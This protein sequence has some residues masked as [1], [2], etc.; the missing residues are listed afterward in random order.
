MSNR[1]YGDFHRVRL[2][3]RC[4]VPI[5]AEL[6]AGE[7]AAADRLAEAHRLLAG[8]VD[9]VR[10]LERMG[11]AGSEVEAVRDELVHQFL[12]TAGPYLSRSD[13]PRRFV[14]AEL[15]KRQRHPLGAGRP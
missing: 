11:V 15:A 10:A 8:S 3:V 6:F 12:Q 7:A 13:F 14:V 1:Y 4:A 2:E 9:Y 5:D